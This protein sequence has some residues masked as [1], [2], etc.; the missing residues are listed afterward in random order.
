MN[1]KPFLAILIAGVIASTGC[2]TAGTGSGS[3]RGS[4][5]AVNFTWQSTDSISGNIAATLGTGRVFNGTYFQITSETRVDRLDPLWTGWGRPSRRGSWRYWAYESR[6]ELVRTY[7]GQVLANMRAEDGEYM[8]CNFTLI[9]PSRG[10][11]DGGV[12]TCQ[13]SESEQEINAEFPREP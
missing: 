8:R 7:T 5:D 10:L 11:M 13:L 12:G 4:R 9:S 2:Q 6:S 3:V 1:R